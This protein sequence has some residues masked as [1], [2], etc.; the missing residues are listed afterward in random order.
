MST[1]VSGLCWVRGGTRH[2]CAAAVLVTVVSTTMGLLTSVSIPSASE[3]EKLSTTLTVPRTGAATWTGMFSLS[4]TLS[5]SPLLGAGL[6]LATPEFSSQKIVN[7]VF[8]G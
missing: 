3:S 8:S 7:P 5:P 6:D 2:C 4:C 1:A